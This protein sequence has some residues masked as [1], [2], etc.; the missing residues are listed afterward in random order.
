[1][2]VLL[3]ILYWCYCSCLQIYLEKFC[4]LL[5]AN[6]FWNL[7]NKGRQRSVFWERIAWTV[8]FLLTNLFLGGCGFIIL[9][10]K[11]FAE[12]E[13]Y[14]FISFISFKQIYQFSLKLKQ[15]KAIK[16]PHIF[17]R[18]NFIWIN[19]PINICY[20]FIHLVYETCS[21]LHGE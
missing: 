8:K 10:H 4:L 14:Q 5:W 15:Q 21:H 3:I 19:Y 6:I 9:I 20:F 13:I 18:R 7:C 12:N 1:M 16:L 11:Y 17:L 2:P